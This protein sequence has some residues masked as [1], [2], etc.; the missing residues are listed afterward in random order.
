MKRLWSRLGV[1][2]AS[3]GILAAGLTGGVYLGQDRDVQQQG[4][5]AQ[6]VAQANLDEIRLL[7][8]RQADH[9]AARAHRVQAEEAAAAKAASEVKAAASKAR[10][11]EKKVIEAKEAAEAKEAEEASGPVVFTGEIPSSCNEYS[12]SREIGCALMLDAGFGLDQFPCL[13][14]LWKKES[15]WNYKAENSSSG[16]Y[17]IPQALPGS[18]MASVAD[19]WKTNPATQIKWGLGY[20]EGR[21]DTPCG[22]WGHSQDVGWY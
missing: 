2:A 7:K 4:A 14:K 17:G 21:Y 20:I 13:D 22:A 11:L 12:G 10:T 18:K 16:A 15:G 3:V 8:Q 5:E 1:R 19:D 6:L 9:A